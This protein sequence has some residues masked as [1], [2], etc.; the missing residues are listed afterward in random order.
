MNIKD[1]AQ[2]TIFICF[3]ITVPVFA[4]AYFLYSNTRLELE[5]VFDKSFGAAFGFFG[6][7]A[8]L[9]AA[10]IATKLFNDW[11]IQ[12][13]HDTKKEQIHKIQSINS[14]LNDFIFLKMEKLSEIIGVYGSQSIDMPS[15]HK[16]YELELFRIHNNVLKNLTE[17]KVEVQNYGFIAVET[18]L[19]KQMI[20]K[21]AIQ[22]AYLVELFKLIENDL[23]TNSSDLKSRISK[24]KSFLGTEIPAQLYESVTY[25][26]ISKLSSNN[27]HTAHKQ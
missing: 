2:T 7:A 1:I 16:D 6:G 18:E 19:T 27:S 20:E 8:T 4:F 13:N 22:E 9:A 17:M 25:P 26:L 5:E 10:Y 3:L 11:R 12:A 23:I 14:L 24:Y 15:R 21:I